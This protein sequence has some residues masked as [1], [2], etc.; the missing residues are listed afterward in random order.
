MY[1]FFKVSWTAP[2]LSDWHSLLLDSGN[3][4]EFGPGGT[5]AGGNSG[6]VGIGA[7]SGMG[8]WELNLGSRTVQL[9]GRSLACSDWCGLY[10]SRDR[11]LRDLLT[12]RTPNYKGYDNFRESRAEGHN[13]RTC[14]RTRGMYQLRKRGPPKGGA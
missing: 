8:L 6:G 14:G 13:N 5:A 11:C 2:V 4:P 1:L 12:V 7:G 10:L 9:A 3:T